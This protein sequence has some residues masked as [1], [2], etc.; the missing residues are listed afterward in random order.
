MLDPNLLV[1]FGTALGM[2]G[3]LLLSIDALGAQDF[4]ASMDAEKEKPFQMTYVG[5][6]AIIN[7]IFVYLAVS[8]FGFL[9]LL[10]LSRN[11]IVLSLLFA[12]FIYFAWK[13]VI[14]V[15]D[16]VVHLFRKLAPRTLE[17]GKKSSCLFVII[18]LIHAIIWIIPF[19]LV[20]IIGMIIRFGLDLPLRFISERLAVPFV[21]WFYEASARLV[22]QDKKWHLKRTVIIGTLFLLF[23]FIYQF[24][25]VILTIK[26]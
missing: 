23:G 4:L 7:N 10:I 14:Y 6:L 19:A 3:S 24:I 2:I 21:K 9:V 16:Q 25:G 8:I 12:P 1:L 18:R 26:W 20:S 17:M 13:G 5:F 11:N 15:S 22:T